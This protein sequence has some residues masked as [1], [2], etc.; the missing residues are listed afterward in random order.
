MLKRTPWLMLAVGCC[1]VI[2]TAQAQQYIYK[3]TDSQGQIQ[4]SELSPP[5][6]VQ[7]EMV[8]KPAGSGQETG[9]Q[10]RE[11][12]KDQE[13]LARQVAEQQRKEEEQAE[14]ARKEAED[15]RAK[16]CEIARKNVQVLQGDSP[17][18]KPDAKGNKVAL[19]AEQRQAELQKA[20][21]DQDYFC[22]P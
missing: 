19:D 17:V 4:Y 20:Q 5:P 18:V 16:N 7:Y 1:A 6:G 15:V 2:A 21:K 3:W 13:E 10:A 8:R 12:T 9:P 14:Q 22:N 11:L